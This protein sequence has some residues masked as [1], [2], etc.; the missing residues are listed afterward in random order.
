[1][2]KHR[3][4]ARRRM[5][6]VLPPAMISGAAVATVA[7][8]GGVAVTNPES[9][10]ST[11]YDLSALIIEGSSTNPTGGGIEDFYGGKFQQDPAVT[12]NFFTGPFGIYDALGQ[13]VTD[14]DNVVLSSG[15][16]AAN[17][18]LLLTYLD[19]SGGND[20]VANNAVYVLDNNVASPNG[21]FG[22]RYPIFAL[23]GVNPIPTPSAPG[24]QV[25]NVVYEY[26]INGNTPAYFL[27]GV[28][29]ANSLV[30]YFGNRLNQQDRV[31]PVGT[32]GQPLCDGA[33]EST[34]ETTGS[35]VR[36]T[37]VEGDPDR[38]RFEVLGANGAVVQSGYVE[39]H[40]TTTYVSYKAN[41]LPLVQPLRTYG[42]AVGNDVADALEP[43][44]TDIV[45]YG[46]PNNDPL[47]DPEQYKPAGL[48]PNLGETRGFIDNLSDDDEP[49]AATVDS[50][51]TATEAETVQ[52]VRRPL[53]D[54]LRAGPRFTP[55]GAGDSGSSAAGD[56]VRP[57]PIHDA[58]SGF[59]DA[60]SGVAE[61]L[62][63]K[64]RKPEAPS[65][66]TDTA[67]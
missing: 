32:D 15:W 8:V 36:F 60:V 1:M 61:S 35:T 48:I 49:S 64:H 37:P 2:A 6:Q 27:N 24:V 33:C 47:A 62:G 41:G 46:Y 40:G 21:G 13:N 5:T 44:L 22:T 38:R 55:G 58:I 7:A 18:S 54:V 39:E 65:D 52:P 20:P 25:V 53:T 45:N 30:G 67:E 43:T 34:D 26:D 16:G 63:G 14:D 11:M 66:S 10:A 3:T 57:R 29:M 31:L 17:A 56:S 19:A 28:A 4:K 12:V 50:T 59:R 51:A 9:V 23:I 42:G